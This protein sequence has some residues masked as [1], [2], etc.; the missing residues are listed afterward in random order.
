MEENKLNK[1]KQI[2]I[3]KINF[4]PT[5]KVPYINQITRTYNCKK[6][7]IMNL[8]DSKIRTRLQFINLK[9]KPTYFFLI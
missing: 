7:E 5:A 9:K 1:E 2:L 8:K 4:N 3:D 6:Y